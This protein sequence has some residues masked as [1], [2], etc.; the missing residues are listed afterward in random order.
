MKYIYD[1]KYLK[2]TTYRD[3]YMYVHRYENIKKSENEIIV[4]KIEITYL[5]N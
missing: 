2:S 3:E 4:F 1:K 5:I